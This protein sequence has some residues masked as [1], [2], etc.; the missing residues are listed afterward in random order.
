MITLSEKWSLEFG[1]KFSTDQ[2]PIKSKTK[3]LVMLSPTKKERKVVPLTLT[4][5]FVV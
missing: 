3:V 1:I 4:M 2:D 5:H